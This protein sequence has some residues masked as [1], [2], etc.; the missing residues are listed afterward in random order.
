MMHVTD[1]LIQISHSLC[2]LLDDEFN[3]IIESCIS[4]IN[5]IDNE[6]EHF[7]HS[8]YNSKNQCMMQCLINLNGSKRRHMKRYYLDL[9]GANVTIKLM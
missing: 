8:T 3:W 2:L 5:Y 9:F 1:Y 6:F 4:L 7:R